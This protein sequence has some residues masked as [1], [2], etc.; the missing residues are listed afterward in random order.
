MNIKKNMKVSKP[1][2]KKPSS[3]NY[4]FT[5]PKIVRPTD[6]FLSKT[7]N[8][9]SKINPSENVPSEDT[10]YYYYINETPQPSSAINEEQQIQLNQQ[11]N[12]FNNIT[13]NYY[14]YYYTIDGAPDANYNEFFIQSADNKENS[15]CHLAKSWR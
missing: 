12:D 15:N 6:E 11:Q 1:T 9:V 7:L 14:Y 8:T 4:R 10:Y 5:S 3:K 13:G 2:V